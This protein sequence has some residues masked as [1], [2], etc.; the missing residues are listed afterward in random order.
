MAI[1]YGATRQRRGRI[2]L[3][4]LEE[5]GRSAAVKRGNVARAEKVSSP[6]RLL[7]DQIERK[8]R[9]DATRRRVSKL[10]ET[11]AFAA[12]FGVGELFLRRRWVARVGDAV[13]ERGLLCRKQ[14][15]RQQTEKDAS[16]FHV[17][18][19]DFRSV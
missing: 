18:W 6:G 4:G 19:K 3:A 11:D 13:R 2:R 17:S 9:C 16:Q 12:Q 8:N 5:N 7:E 15:Q 1:Q 14:Q 10:F